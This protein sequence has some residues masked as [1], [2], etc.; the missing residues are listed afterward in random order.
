MSSRKLLEMS[1]V[2]AFALLL[3]VGWV[4]VFRFFANVFETPRPISEIYG[5]QIEP[6]TAPTLPPDL[7]AVSMDDKIFTPPQVDEN[8]SEAF[9]PEGIYTVKGFTNPGFSD[10]ES[11]LISNKKL[12]VDCDD[13]EFGKLVEPSGFVLFTN[14]KSGVESTLDIEALRISDGGLTF[15]T[16]PRDGVRYSFAGEFLV[17]GNFYTLDPDTKVLRGTLAKFKDG[18]R[19]AET[20]VSFTWSID[21]TCVC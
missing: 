11:I 17:R 12:D 20:E 19:V 14:P 18:K 15:E 13:A 1:V 10:V 7:P 21:L 2:F 3:G 16:D 9:D 6:P 4:G 5:R 8:N